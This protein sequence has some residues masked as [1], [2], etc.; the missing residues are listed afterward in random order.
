MANNI[1]QQ[2]YTTTIHI[3]EEF[4]DRI[5]ASSL[6]SAVTFVT[7]SVLICSGQGMYVCEFFS[8]WY[9]SL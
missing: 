1:K 9:V 8:T 2:S 3:T 5:I 4:K 6:A 7:L